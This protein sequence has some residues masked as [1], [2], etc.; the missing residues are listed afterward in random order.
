M[1]SRGFW[2]HGAQT[3]V[4]DFLNL[5]LLGKRGFRDASLRS[6]TTWHFRS[7]CSCLLLLGTPGS[8]GPLGCEPGPQ[9]ATAD[10]ADVT[11][12][13]SRSE[14]TPAPPAPALRPLP[15]RPSP[16]SSAAWSTSY[17]APDFVPGP[18][19]PQE[20]PEPQCLALAELWLPGSRGGSGHTCWGPSHTS[21]P[22][23]PPEQEHSELSGLDVTFPFGG[24]SG[25]AG[26]RRAQ[27]RPFELGLLVSRE[28]GRFGTH[29]TK[30]RA[31][32]SPS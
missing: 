23:P 5:G 29:L 25:P 22:P 19:P 32:H 8:P 9:A 6:A 13:L 31:F 11:C 2:A 3:R 27:A 21:A 7:P 1:F 26:G 18:Q 24:A 15:P 17:M 30:E 20:T 10:P 4:L 12:R 16:T 28:D 14:S